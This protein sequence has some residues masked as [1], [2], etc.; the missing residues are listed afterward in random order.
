MKINTYLWTTNITQNCICN[1]KHPAMYEC[2]TLFR[3]FPCVRFAWCAAFPALCAQA[4]FDPARALARA[5]F[6]PA[7]FF[8]IRFCT[9]VDMRFTVLKELIKESRPWSWANSDLSYC[10]PKLKACYKDQCV[11]HCPDPNPSANFRV[12][13]ASTAVVRCEF[14]QHASCTLYD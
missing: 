6:P 9:N 12:N 13:P 10:K 8:A 1:C 5:A 2:N 3:G 14:E 7:D 11:Y 4:L